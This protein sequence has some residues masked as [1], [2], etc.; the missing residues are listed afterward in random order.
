MYSRSLCSLRN[1][2]QQ[3]CSKK[4]KF[5]QKSLNFPKKTKFSKKGQ[6][7]TKSQILDN[8]DFFWLFLAFLKILAFLANFGFILAFLENFGFHVAY[9]GGTHRVQKSDVDDSIEGTEKAM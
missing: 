8:F 1:D 5:L 7:L 3:T 2:K 9:I 4:Y 6:N